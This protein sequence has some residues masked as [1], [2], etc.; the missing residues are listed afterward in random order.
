[1]KLKKWSQLHDT[2]D[3]LQLS[4]VILFWPSWSAVSC[5]SEAQHIAPLS[6]DRVGPNKVTNETWGRSDTLIAALPIMMSI[7]HAN[8]AVF[9][10]NK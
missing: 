2:L 1:M 8:N 5:D 9:D 10:Q 7:A 3:L 4:F 6:R